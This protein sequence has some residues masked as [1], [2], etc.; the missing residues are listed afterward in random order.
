M[1]LKTLLA[2]DRTGQWSCLSIGDSP[3]KTRVDNILS[4]NQGGQQQ[5]QSL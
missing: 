3:I 2:D 5:Q 1:K 4:C